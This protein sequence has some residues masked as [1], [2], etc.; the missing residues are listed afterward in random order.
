M[1]ARLKFFKRSRPATTSY[2]KLQNHGGIWNATT[3]SARQESL[4]PSGEVIHSQMERKS[5]G[6]QLN[7][8]KDALL[9]RPK[10]IHGKILLQ[11]STHKKGQKAMWIFSK[12]TSG[13][14]HTSAP[15]VLGARNGTRITVSKKKTDLLIGTL[16]HSTDA[17]LVLI[18]NE[19]TETGQATKNTDQSPLN[20]PI[21][22][23]EISHALK[24]L[25]SNATGTDM[26]HN[27]QYT[28]I[29]NLSSDNREL[30]RQVFN[31]LF[32]NG[33]TPNP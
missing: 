21:T 14:N 1:E 23:D 31:N 18:Q 13:R 2:Q 8:K 15:T 12:S 3:V 6:R 16:L 19:K 7:P 24:N 28:M 4:C 11:I 32:I 30:L 17:S 22:T 26:V 29:A 25:K 5:R 20:N 10:R 27:N 9:S 33:T